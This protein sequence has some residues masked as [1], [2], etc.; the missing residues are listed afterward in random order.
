MHTVDCA[1]A[2]RDCT[3]T[4]LSPACL[5]QA[6]NIYYFSPRPLWGR[7]LLALFPA[8]IEGSG[9]V[10]CAVSHRDGYMTVT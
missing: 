3:A 8:V 4:P 7:A 9:G 5:E 6:N 1:R 10:Y 2:H